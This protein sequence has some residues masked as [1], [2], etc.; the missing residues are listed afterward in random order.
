MNSSCTGPCAR[1]AH[2]LLRSK[3]TVD[4]ELIFFRAVFARRQSPWSTYNMMMNNAHDLVKYRTHL[5]LSQVHGSEAHGQ[6]IINNMSDCEIISYRAI[7]SKLI[8]IDWLWTCL[9]TAMCTPT[10]LMNYYE[11]SSRCSWSHWFTAVGPYARRQSSWS[12]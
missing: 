2:E 10:E 12:S 3:L 6:W 4:G 8:T 11:A 9:I 1:Q 5:V 7:K